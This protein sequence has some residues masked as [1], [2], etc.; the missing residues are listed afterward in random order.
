[1]RTTLKFQGF[2]GFGIFSVFGPSSRIFSE[3]S[4]LKRAFL[5]DPGPVRTF[6]RQNIDFICQNDMLFV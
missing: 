3:I 6:T 4:A 5:R 1:M 2:A